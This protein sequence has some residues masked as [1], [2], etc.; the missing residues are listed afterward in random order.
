M[1]DLELLGKSNTL[2]LN[3][4]VE[5]STFQKMEEVENF[6]W[7]QR[8]RLYVVVGIVSLSGDLNFS[9]GVVSRDSLM[10][11]HVS[12]FI[13]LIRKIL[14]VEGIVRSSLGHLYEGGRELPPMSKEGAN[15]TSF[16]SFQ[17]V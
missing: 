6:L 1:E 17:G 2:P 11:S 15:P 12:L 8:R 5:S 7:N 10:S 14:L 16:T 9:R 13:L 3:P 4:S